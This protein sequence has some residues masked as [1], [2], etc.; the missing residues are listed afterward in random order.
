M[1]RVAELPDEE[2][3]VP[4]Q[5]GVMGSYP[6]YPLFFPLIDSSDLKYRWQS[7]TE[8][9]ETT[10]LKLIG[11]IFILILLFHTSPLTMRGLYSAIIPISPYL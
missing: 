2:R 1:P 3:K 5:E 4:R 10:I 9:V 8:A 11:H 7:E 6:S